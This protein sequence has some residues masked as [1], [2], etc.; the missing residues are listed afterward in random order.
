MPRG[1]VLA[2]KVGVTDPSKGLTLKRGANLYF[3]TASGQLPTSRYPAAG[4]AGI[5]ATSPYGVTM[6]DRSA[7]TGSSNDALRGYAA[8]ADNLVL[9]FAP[10]AAQA[11]TVTIQ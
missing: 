2:F 10:W 7:A 5:G 3:S 6:F 1:P 8:F 9:D 4:A 11:V